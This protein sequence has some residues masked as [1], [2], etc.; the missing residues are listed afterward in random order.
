[1]K[2]YVQVYTGDGKCKT[3][4]ALGLTLRAVGAGLRVY[5]GQFIKGH[6]YSEI[7]LL[8]ERFPE[9]MVEQYGAGKF[10]RG[11]P[12]ADEVSAGHSG[13]EALTRALHSGLYDVV[14]ADE[15]STAVMA[16][17]FTEQ[18]LLN[19]IGEKPDSVEL[20]LTG[21]GAGQALQDR[22][23]LVTDMHCV[24]HYFNAGVRGRKGIES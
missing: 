10:I 5:L 15:A 13:L 24:K 11:A 2:G 23:D 14:I 22:A 7:R 4:A 16:G 19:L 9:V 20:V 3:T 8:R 12:T 1:M 17:L 6:E 21:R 18:D